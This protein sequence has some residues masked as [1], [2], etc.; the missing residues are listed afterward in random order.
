MGLAQFDG[1]CVAR[2]Q[3]L[4]FALAAAVP[5]RAHGMNHLPR[6][7]PIPQGDF[8]VAGLAAMKGAAFGQKLWTSG[9]V[10]GPIHAAAAEQGRVGGVDEGVNA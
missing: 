6:R 7:Q 9:A 4:I 5:D 1:T 2:R 10:D 3:R 8:G